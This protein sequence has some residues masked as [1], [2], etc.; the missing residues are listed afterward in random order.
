[1]TPSC[2]MLRYINIVKVPIMHIVIMH[3]I[4]KGLYF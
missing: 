1:M 2:V 4:Y 3:N